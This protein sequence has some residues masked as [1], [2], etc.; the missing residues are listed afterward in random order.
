M[1][2]SESAANVTACNI[3]LVKELKV[4]VGLELC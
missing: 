3:T 1:I 4:G 2:L